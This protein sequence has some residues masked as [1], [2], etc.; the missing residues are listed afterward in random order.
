MS[1]QKNA[2]QLVRI[3]VD[4]KAVVVEKLENNLVVERDRFNPDIRARRVD[5]AKRLGVADA[6]LIQWID[7]V[8]TSSQNGMILSALSKTYTIP[9]ATNAVGDLIV[10]RMD[11]RDDRGAVH[12]LVPDK[13]LTELLPT[14]AVDQLMTWKDIDTLCCLDIDY[15]EPGRP[16]PHES[17]LA[18]RVVADLAPRPFA[19]HLSR[20]GGLHLFYIA[21]DPFTAEELA[22]AAALAWR[23]IDETAGV[24]L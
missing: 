7:D 8:R 9:R 13:I 12:P 19:W 10:R 14:V 20:K 4:K 24:E 17:W 3:S 11:E 1:I 18:A 21:S 15:H 22:A 23:R 16:A 5:S 6:T 2:D